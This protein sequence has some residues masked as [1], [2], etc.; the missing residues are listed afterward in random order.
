MPRIRKVVG[1]WAYLVV[2]PAQLNWNYSL[3]YY[4]LLSQGHLDT[5]MNATYYHWS[6]ARSCVLLVVPW[7]VEGVVL[8][9]YP[10]EPMKMVAAD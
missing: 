9:C 5:Q 7:Q 1:I 8:G 10:L 6:E 2:Y 4:H 3:T